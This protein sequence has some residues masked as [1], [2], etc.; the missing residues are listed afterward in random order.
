MS[1]GD[2]GSTDAG[3]LR[4]VPPAPDID[5]WIACLGE[6]DMA[7]E[8]LVAEGE[9]ARAARI[10]V[11]ARRRAFLFR[12]AVRRHVLDQYSKT[13][14][15]ER[16]RDAKPRLA[17]TPPLHFNASSSQHVCA[18]AVA[19]GEVGVDIAATPAPV[20]LAWLCARFVP[21][22]AEPENGPGRV[23]RAAG[24]WQWTRF[25]AALKLRGEL[26]FDALARRGG[27]CPERHCELLV[28]GPGFVC[29]VARPVPFR[30]AGLEILPFAEVAAHAG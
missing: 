23:R 12:R 8:D 7:A 28:S 25:E 14:R 6:D 16:M 11:P 30:L 21:G 19:T 5:L 13:W 26:L 17:G 24:Q 10:L 15:V 9:R 20:D 18:V 3:A 22:F 1:A 2:W 27:Q 29:A 4:A